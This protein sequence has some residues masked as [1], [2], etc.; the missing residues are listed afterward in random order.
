MTPQLRASLMRFERYREQFAFLR[1]NGITTQGELDAF[2]AKTEERVVALTK[3]RTILNVRKKKRQALYAALA[4]AEALAPVK[5]CCESGLIGLKDEHARY[6]EAVEALDTC[7][8]SQE[9]L[10]AEKA[11][12]YEELAEVN[13]VIRAERKKLRLCAEIAG[14]APRI[15]RELERVEDEKSKQTVRKA[16][17]E[18]F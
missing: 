13:R 14:E 10:A 6:T 11:A 1:E 5:E 3:R 8:I 12:L 15:E 17:Q 16:E 4:D 7:G 9:R 2:S 18:R